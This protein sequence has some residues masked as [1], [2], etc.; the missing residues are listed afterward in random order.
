LLLTLGELL[1]K[2]P[3]HE[4]KAFKEWVLTSQEEV[5]PSLSQILSQTHSLAKPFLNQ[6]S[7][8]FSKEIPHDLP[9]KRAI[10]HHIDL[11][12]GATL[13]TNRPIGCTLN[14]P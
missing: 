6:L 2:A 5:E 11:I 7:H 14:K 9:P 3:L 4:F 1:L 13:L 10:K 12:L 8:V